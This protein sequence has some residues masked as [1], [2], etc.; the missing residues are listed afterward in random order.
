MIDVLAAVLV[1]ISGVL[2]VL[3]GLGLL[4]FPDAVTRLHAAAKSATIGLISATL[5]AALE[6]DTIGAASLLVLVSALLLLSAPIGTTL[7]ARAAYYDRDTELL[8]PGGDALATGPKDGRAPRRDERSGEAGLLVG[9]LAVV[10]IGLFAAPTPGVLLGALAIGALV[11]LLLPGFRPRWPRGLFR[12]VALLRFVAVF[13]WSLIAANLEVVRT[14]L[15]RR[16]LQT[17]ILTV[18]LRVASPTALTLLVNAVTFTPGS[19]VIELTGSTLY[20]HLLDARS[21]ASFRADIDRLERG[22]IAAFGTRRERERLP[23]HAGRFELPRNS[24]RG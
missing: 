1:L 9:W 20:V 3:A 23:A 15:S 4:R 6:V 12:P 5:A 8:L 21:E 19:V 17:A 14:V 18:P 16:P 22:I 11:A 7:L 24:G 13:V 2:A 10:W